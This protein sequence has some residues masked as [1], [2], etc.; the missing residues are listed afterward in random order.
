MCFLLELLASGRDRGGG[1]RFFFLLF[2]RGWEGGRGSWSVQ[3]TIILIKKNRFFFSWEGE[4][5]GM[6]KKVFF[7]PFYIFSFGGGGGGGVED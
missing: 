4:G 5:E 1:V 6:E 3:E 2:L 7:F